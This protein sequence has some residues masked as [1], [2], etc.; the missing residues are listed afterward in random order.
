M[1]SSLAPQQRR[2]L[3]QS[4]TPQVTPTHHRGKGVSGN[5]RFGLWDTEP[6]GWSYPFPNMPILI[7]EDVGPLLGPPRTPQPERN[8]ICEQSSFIFTK[9]NMVACLSSWP[10]TGLA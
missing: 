7:F 2:A 5:D 4:S 9:M 3:P 8:W 6:W 1:G 10:E